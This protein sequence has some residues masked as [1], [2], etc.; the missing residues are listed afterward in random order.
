MEHRLKNCNKHKY[1]GQAEI[2]CANY[3]CALLLFFDPS[4]DQSCKVCFY[5]AKKCATCKKMP[6][7]YAHGSNNY[8]VFL[9]AKKDPWTSVLN[10]E[11]LRA[12]KKRFLADERI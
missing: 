8:F 5:T 7:C 2:A 10:P 6:Y 3:L 9:R 11:K 12:R 4:K 1:R